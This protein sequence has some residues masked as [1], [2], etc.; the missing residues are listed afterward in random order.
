MHP[1]VDQKELGRITGTVIPAYF[2][3]KPADEMV[4]HLLWMTLGD[5][6]HYSPL[7]HVWVV[8]DGDPRTERI[9]ASVQDRMLRENGS[10]F[11]LMPLPENRG[12]LWAM[13]T[14]ISALLDAQTGV[15]Y[16][17][18][19]DGDG[20][21]AV[22]EVP[23]LVR[24]ALHLSEVYGSTRVIA[25]G[26]RRSRHHPMGWI[27]GELEALL[28]GVTLDALAYV[29]AREGRV[30]DLANRSIG[31][32]VPD[33]S[34][35][36]KAY[37]RAI[38]HELFQA[39][40]DWAGGTPNGATLSVADYWHYGP[41]T[42]TMVEAL[43]AGCAWGEKRRLTWDG[44]PTTSFGEFRHLL[45]Y[46]ELLAWVF[47]RLSLPLDVAAQIVDNRVP[48][49]ALRT[50]AHGRELLSELRAFALDRVCAFRGEAGPPNPPR[51]TI[52]FL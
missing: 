3:V 44:Q 31:G 10:T 19:R 23:G 34:S 50:T 37:G 11:C 33:L 2:S 41:E 36:F 48:A 51:A 32:A 1:W 29:L 47:A 52:P 43:L 16:V 4:E 14:G 6:P 17:V 40:E 46:G 28:D 22:S 45:L 39:N 24:T 49:L 12:K 35:G 9:A 8:V 25:I 18:I 5:C 13:K 26:A 7:E 30:L 20:D 15:Q 42:V 21:H 27:R 38:A